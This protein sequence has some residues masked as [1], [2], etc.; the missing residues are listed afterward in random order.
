M[1]RVK[2]SNNTYST[3]LKACDPL[4]RRLG[5]RCGCSMCSRMKAALAARYSSIELGVEFYVNNDDRYW[6][7]EI[8]FDPSLDDEFSI[9][10][11]KQQARLSDRMWQLLKE[12]NV[13]A[14][15]R[16][17]RTRYDQATAK[18]KEEQRQQA[19]NEPSPPEKAMEETET[20]MPRPTPSR[21][22]KGKQR[23]LQEATRRAEESGVETEAVMPKVEREAQPRYK[24]AS[25]A[26]PRSAAF[27]EVQQF[28]GQTRV[29]LNEQHPF[30]TR[31]YQG[32]SSTPDVRDALDLLLLAI[33]EAELNSEGDRKLF[34]ET[35][36]AQ[37]SQRLNVG[38]ERWDQI[39]GREERRD[40][41]TTAA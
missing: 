20:F 5:H 39:V 13:L 31:I 35:E 6:G 18:L 3:N 38:I 7:I 30:F 12:H 24:V 10:T 17:L 8:D 19:D 37:W 23:L 33:A 29:I 26:M 1:L 14:A 16:E 11:S 25:K 21:A 9:T 32:P 27:F 36:R 22:A 4:G 40:E 2:V 41:D 28:G 15:I 34:Y